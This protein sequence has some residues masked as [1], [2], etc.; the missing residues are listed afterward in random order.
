MEQEH[1]Q[2]KQQ[3]EQQLQEL[4]KRRIL[5]QRRADFY[6]QRQRELEEA[7]QARQAAKED[8]KEKQQKLRQQVLL[9]KRFIKDRAA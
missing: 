3:S 7:H 6:A 2:V 8:K 9:A 4:Q 5:E 1:D